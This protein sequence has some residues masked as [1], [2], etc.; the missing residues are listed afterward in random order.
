[1]LQMQIQMLR[2]TEPCLLTLISYNDVSG[3][4]RS[5]NDNEEIG[6]IARARSNDSN[7]TGNTVSG[8]LAG[9]RTRIRTAWFIGQEIDN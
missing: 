5:N 4:N 8:N 9:K 6:I 1:M 7:C 3:E 2:F